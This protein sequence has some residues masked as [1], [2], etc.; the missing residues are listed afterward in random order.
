MES[1]N[2]TPVGKPMQIEYGG[3]TFT[4]ENISHL[5]TVS[6]TKP[7]AGQDTVDTDDWKRNSPDFFT[8]AQNRA[9]YSRLFTDGT[10]A[11]NSTSCDAY[12]KLTHQADCAIGS[13][14]DGNLSKEE[15]SDQFESMLDS[16]IND[17]SEA[18]YSHPLLCGS[19]W[20]VQSQ[21]ESFYKE[22][23]NK[24]LQLAVSRNDAE[25]Q[26]YVSGGKGF[27]GD[28]KYYNSDYYY[29]TEDA[30]SALMNGV[31]AYTKDRPGYEDFDLQEIEANYT[32]YTPR[33]FNSAW[34]NRYPLNQ[35]CLMDE[36]QAPP[37]GF[38]WFYQK[39]GSYG[40][41]HPVIGKVYLDGR[42]VEQTVHRAPF[43]PTKDTSATTWASYRDA[44]GKE[45]R[46]STDFLF[47]VDGV[48]KYLMSTLLQ[49]TGGKAQAFNQFLENLRV[50]S[51]NWWRP[52][53]TPVID[54][55]F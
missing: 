33:N 52:D 31:T 26:Q 2:N 29:K 13:F 15:L 1:I 46:V 24:I 5:L 41:Q 27:N 35:Q 25:G 4:V 3:K 28:W 9:F 20:V 44:S 43:D 45:H 37:E 23:R 40:K 14:L 21:T 16:F 53:D 7:D 18:G 48:D 6:D 34:N 19:K 49:F 51:G 50:N 10:L 38:K 47:D 12:S 8:P 55:R 36:K 32:Q 17:C 22:M 30:L 11:N 39:G 42:E 54:L